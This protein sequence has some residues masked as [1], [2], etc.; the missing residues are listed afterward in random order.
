MIGQNA[1]V[2]G[3]RKVALPDYALT[4]MRPVEDTI[5]FAQSEN[6]LQKGGGARLEAEVGMFHHRQQPPTQR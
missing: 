1:T 5:V 2:Q 3:G 4:S 6:G